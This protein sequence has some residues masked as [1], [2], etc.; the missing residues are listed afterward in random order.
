MHSEL[1]ELGAWRAAGLYTNNL[2]VFDP[3]G[4]F[5]DVY[6]FL[7]NAERAKVMTGSLSDA[8]PRVTSLAEAKRTLT[9]PE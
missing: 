4:W 3:D 9:R 8:L 5:D 7:S 1:A 2:A 6:K